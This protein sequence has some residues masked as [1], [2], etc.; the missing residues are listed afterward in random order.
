MEKEGLDRRG[1]LKGATWVGALGVG[2]ATA[3]MMLTGCTEKEPEE[4]EEVWDYEVDVAIG[5]FGMGG[6]VAA[7][8]AQKAGASVIAFESFYQVGGTSVDSG[9]GASA[10]ATMEAAKTNMPYGNPVLMKA[11]I[12]GLPKARDVL[13]ELDIPVRAPA[14][15]NGFTLGIESTHPSRLASFEAMAKV[16][17]DNGGTLLMETKAIK[18]LTDEN[19]AICGIVARDKSGK[20]LNVKA[21]AVIL[22][23]GGFQ[24]NNELKTR[25]FGP[26]GD[27]SVCRAVP[28]NDGTGL[29]MAQA[30]GAGLSQGLGTFYGHTI[31][32]DIKVDFMEFQGVGTQAHDNRS[33]CVNLDGVRY[34][35]EGMGVAGDLGNQALMGERWGRAA[36]LFD[37]NIYDT[38]GSHSASGIPTGI[39]RTKE[40]MNRGGRVASADTIEDLAKKISAWGYNRAAVIKTVKEYNDAVDAGT[41]ADLAV[42]RTTGLIA[43]IIKL[44]KPPFWATEVVPG[45]SCCYGGLL[46]NEKG[47]VLLDEPKTPI[48]GLYAAPGTAGGVTAVHYYLSSIG[49]AASFGWITADSAVKY[50]ASL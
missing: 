13:V 27:M 47:E 42:P 9:G 41:T 20:I 36:L 1:F 49:A 33:I 43:S 25:F 21:K 2:A 45:I 28:T 50:I 10:P 6:S 16:F 22:A 35:D 19:G 23:C 44:E 37:Q 5:G 3:G 34:T 15:S 17:T 11:F 40:V 18:L 48:P 14:T 39:D 46:I 24:N 8:T 32:A 7:L 30:I 4:P 12:E 38:F 31:A 26:N 29:L